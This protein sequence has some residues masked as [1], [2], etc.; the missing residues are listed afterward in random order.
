MVLTP[1]KCHRA[2]S[3]MDEVKGIFPA[4]DQ[5]HCLDH[6]RLRSPKWSCFQSSGLGLTL[7]SR[8]L[9]VFGI[10]MTSF[11]YVIQGKEHRTGSV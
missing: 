2:N 4:P 7:V 11:N 3:V 9:Y 6:R 1:V 5:S 8:W 10:E